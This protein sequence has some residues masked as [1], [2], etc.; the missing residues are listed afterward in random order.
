MSGLKGFA[1]AIKWESVAREVGVVA[2][3]EWS[4]IE[5][6]GSAV[7]LPLV[8]LRGHTADDIEKALPRICA[9]FSCA[10]GQVERSRMRMDK[11]RLWLYFSNLDDFI[12]YQNPSPTRLV[13]PAVSS[14][15]PL[16][17]GLDGVTHS[18][19]LFDD[20]VG[21]SSLL[22]GGV[23]GSGKTN[24]LRVVMAGL[25]LTPATILLIDPTGGAEAHL[26]QS[27]VSASV[28]T[29]DANETGVLL[30]EVVRLI[31][32]R[33][34]LLG[35]GVERRDL[36]PVCL[37]CDEL[38]ELGSAS[39]PKEQENLR[40]LLRRVVSL[41]R[42]ANVACVF[43][44]QRTTAASIDVTTRSLVAQKL[45]LPH[46]GDTYGSEALLGPGRHEAAKLT[47]RDRGLGYFS[48]G[49]E[50]KL[51]RVYGM[52]D[53]EVGRYAQRLAGPSL[54]SLGAWDASL[55]RSVGS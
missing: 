48:D 32:R 40:A 42:K 27:R 49:G 3:I 2:R 20:V 5:H 39:S 53:A 41:G 52:T 17:V 29:G 28:L 45:A 51:I 50:P 1:L 26:W 33:G 10:D 35:K 21:G 18:L 12:P 38:A 44:T 25:S 37:V 54:D 11:V 7:S 9:L 24:A 43:A 31:T 13:P 46:P 55:A 16:G 6:L 23:P 34:H 15:L 4:R 8:L 19:R 36:L 14:P 22:V 30:E 47:V